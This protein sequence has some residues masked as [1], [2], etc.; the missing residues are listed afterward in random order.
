MKPLGPWGR[1]QESRRVAVAVS[2]GADSMAL[3]LLTAGWGSP[4]ALVVDHGLRPESGAEAE[5]TVRRLGARGIPSCLLRLSLTPGAGLAARARQARYD[6]LLAACTREGLADLLLAHHARDQAETVLMREAS[7]SGPFGLAGMSAIQATPQARLLRPLL[8]VP[9]GRLRATL[10]KAGAEWVEDP[11]NRDQRALRPRLRADLADE[12]GT[13]PRTRELCAKAAAHGRDRAAREAE[14]AAILAE[15]VCFYPEG[16]ARLSPG[17][18][19]AM[20]MSGLIQ[21]VSGA[22]YP[23]SLRQVAPL[24]GA[25][26]PVTLTGVRLLPAGRLGPGLLVVREE[27]AMMPDVPALPGAAW[28]RRFRLPDDADWPTDSRMGALGRDASRFRRNSPLPAAVLVTLP[29]VRREGRLLA[30]PHLRW[31]ASPDIDP[32]RILFAPARPAAGAGFLPAV[33]GPAAG[34]GGGC[35]AAQETLC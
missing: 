30:V 2:G 13:A 14:I 9:P 24:A 33:H 26:A 1:R 4:V 10:K 17:P 18:L 20:A 34:C 8:D 6:A 31:S 29:A 35:M 15:R 27:A 21:A 5:L 3:A 25:A 32:G 11:S 23:P 19:P 28:D 12:D 7:G 16:F 22:R